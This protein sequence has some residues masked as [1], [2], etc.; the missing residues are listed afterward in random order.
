MKF[1]TILL[2]KIILSKF[3][4]QKKLLFSYILN[5]KVSFKHLRL[6]IFR[7]IRYHLQDK[8]YE[9]VLTV[10]ESQ[11]AKGKPQLFYQYGPTLMQ[12][13]SRRFV[14]S[15]MANGSILSPLKMIPS[16]LVNAR[17]EQELEAVRYLEFCVDKLGSRDPP[18]H[19]YLLS[20]YIK[21]KP[22][23]VW[24]YLQKFSG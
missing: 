7:V 17:V 22:K 12:T 24:P 3:L 14:D 2:P 13:I 11:L 15:L 6:L 1:K 23:E 4:S 10:L 19:N 9:P 8:E 16:L 20:L 18:V 21:H 5:L